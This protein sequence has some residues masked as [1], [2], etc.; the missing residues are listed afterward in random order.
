MAGSNMKEGD[1]LSLKQFRGP[2]K[3]MARYITFDILFYTRNDL[4]M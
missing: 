1:K 3:G 4:F 2:Q